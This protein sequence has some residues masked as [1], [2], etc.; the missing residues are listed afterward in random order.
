MHFKYERLPNFC[1]HCGLLEHDLKDY[2]Q[3]EEIEKNGEMGELQYGSWMRGDP[4][5]KR[6][7]APDD[8]N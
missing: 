7:R 2:K 5:G 8:E 1:Y 3:N 6:W 4:V